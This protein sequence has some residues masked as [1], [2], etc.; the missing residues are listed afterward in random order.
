MSVLK[1][2]S[3]W[4]LGVGLALCFPAFQSAAVP[5]AGPLRIHPENPRC[6]T[7]GAKRPDGSLRA[8]YLT[9][10][11]TRNNLVDMGPTVSG[12]ER[13]ERRARVGSRQH[14]ARRDADGSAAS[15]AAVVR[16]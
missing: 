4:T 3:P 16:A 7:D 9:G 10:S 15:L 14:R 13:L 6:F 2:R 5:A 8:V 11:H 12:M 1:L